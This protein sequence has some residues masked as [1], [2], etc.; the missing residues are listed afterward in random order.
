MAASEKTFIA[1]LGT[2]GLARNDYS[3]A[4]IKVL[5]AIVKH[6]QEV[7][8]E[9]SVKQR[10]THNRFCLTPEQRESGHVDVT[11]PL[12]E[13]G[14]DTKRTARLR[15]MLDQMAKKPIGIP[16]KV[17]DITYYR[18]FPSL[19]TCETSRDKKK[20]GKWMVTFRFSTAVIC[21]FYSFDKGKTVIDLRVVNQCRSRLTIK[22]YLMVN[23]WAMKG[24]TRCTPKN[25]QLLFFGK[26]NVYQGWSAL[27]LKCLKPAC[28]ELKHLYDKGVV[29][30]Y[31]SYNPCYAAEQEH[32]ASMPIH[33][34]FTLHDRRNSGIMEDGVASDLL[35][36]ERIKLKL[37]LIATYGVKE[38]TAVCLSDLLE[39]DMLG[40]LTDWFLHKD[41]YIEKCKRE[42]RPMNV[43]GYIARGL[44]EFFR[45]HKI[46]L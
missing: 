24:C 18:E 41:Y 5:L 17:G 1:I 27:E 4:E 20:G 32:H 29:H 22:L 36:A 44:S 40:E 30:Q 8:T 10:V 39:L 21:H 33:I 9:Y 23:C 43:G 7:I 42:N 12:S 34:S 45:E 35:K 14:L 38:L 15:N 3:T 28:D 13:L 26:D 25:L 37:K 19:F 16:F 2:Q 11:M 46:Q 31:V 6:A